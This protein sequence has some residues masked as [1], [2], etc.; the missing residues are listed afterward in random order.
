MI[1][2]AKLSGMKISFI[3]V[4]YYPLTSLT[5]HTVDLHVVWCNSRAM[6][7]QAPK[8]QSQV[9]LDFENQTFVELLS[10]DGLIIMAR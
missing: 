10:E 5:I 1:M 7:Q 2:N 8:V 6:A 4:I 3:N 9:I